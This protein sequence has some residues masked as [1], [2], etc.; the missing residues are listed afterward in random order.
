MKR[1][2]LAL[3]I[4]GLFLASTTTTF[5][6]DAEKTIKGEAQCLKCTLKKSDSCA[7][8]IVTKVE[9]KDVIYYLK[10]HEGK[11]VS[12]DFHKQVCS[13]STKKKVE[14]RGTVAEH[15]GK[16]ELTVASIK[17]VD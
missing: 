11:T 4:T 7:S 12:K 15:D 13:P 1:I 10:D 8:V 14:A 17:I 2:I 3:S 5:A 9:G 16:H 6:A